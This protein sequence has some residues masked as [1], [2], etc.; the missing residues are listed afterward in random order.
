MTWF[1]SGIWGSEA[2]CKHSVIR[3][4]VASS[5][6]AN[7]QFYS[8]ENSSYAFNKLDG[9]FFLGL[10]DFTRRFCFI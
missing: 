3:L 2:N 7:T 8:S 6:F 9:D 4:L 10:A 5:S 1:S